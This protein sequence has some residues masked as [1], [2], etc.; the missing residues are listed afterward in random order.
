MPKTRANSTVGLTAWCRAKLHHW[1]ELTAEQLHAWAKTEGWCTYMNDAQRLHAIRTCMHHMVTTK[2]VTKYRP[3][4]LFR[5]TGE[6]A[7][8]REVRDT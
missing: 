1:E 3:A 6:V 8:K 7:Q 2:E 5:W 4:M